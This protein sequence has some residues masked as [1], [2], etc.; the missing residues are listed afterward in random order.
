M[1]LAAPLR[2]GG[3]RRRQRPSPK[4]CQT[5]LS[6]Q[7]CFLHRQFPCQ[8]TPA[9][10]QRSASGPPPGDVSRATDH[11]LWVP[12]TA[13]HRSPTIASPT[14]GRYPHAAGQAAIQVSQP[15]HFRWEIS[16]LARTA[17]CPERPVSGGRSGQPSTSPAWARCYSAMPSRIPRPKDAD[18]RKRAIQS[19]PTLSLPP[20]NPGAPAVDCRR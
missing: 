18:H 12:D 13:H 2:D 20:R 11:E 16:G 3:P 1:I 4:L 15:P 14:V 9:R 17:G 10:R 7:Q 19:A 6:K 8:T 5:D